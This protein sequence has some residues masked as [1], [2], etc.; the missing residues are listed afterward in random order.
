MLRLL[1]C[2]SQHVRLTMLIVI[3]GACLLVC[4][5]PAQGIQR[6]L[7]RDVAT[8]PPSWSNQVDP[9]DSAGYSR[10]PLVVGGIIGALAGGYIGALAIGSCE[11]RSCTRAHSA[12]PVYGVLIGGGVGVLVA[13]V[14]QRLPHRRFR[15]SATRV[16][17]YFDHPPNE[18]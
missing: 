13:A 12:A 15:A 4:R 5:L 7:D 14:I 17:H 6:P 10:K 2:G 18:R 16:P 9:V 1:R 8:R 3:V 11:S